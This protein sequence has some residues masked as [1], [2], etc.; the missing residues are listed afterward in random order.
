MATPSQ[1]IATVAADIGIS[2]TDNK[3]NTWYWGR[4]C[5]DA[6]TY[7]WCACSQSYW[8]DAV[9]GLGYT[10]SASVSG[11]FNQLQRIDD[12]D[13][14]PG[15]YVCY[16]WDGRRDTG[17]MDHIG[18]VE[19]FDHGTDYFGTIE[20]N[21]GNSAGGE[22]ARVTRY[23]EGDYFTAFCRPVY[24]GQTAEPQPRPTPAPSTDAIRYCVRSGGSWLPEMLNLT[25]TGSSGDTWAG[26]GDPIEYIAIDMPGWYQVYTDDS[27]WCDRVYAYN[28]DDLV[29]GCAGD[30]SPIRR[31]RCWYETPDPDATGYHQIEYAVANAGEDFLPG[32]IDLTDTGGSDDDYAGND[33]V[34]GRF[35]AQLVG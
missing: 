16:N 13:V 6:N 33:G 24:D 11:I 23:N 5:Y 3:F 27:G 7:P 10:P 31:I 22:V 1:L 17:W 30:G 20:G 18:L 12:A 25:D 2:G 35:R 32:M 9:G 8:A 19:W 14:Q 26:N 34:M 29:N 4:P 15:D 28:P 21:T